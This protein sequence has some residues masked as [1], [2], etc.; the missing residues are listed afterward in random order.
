M[1]EPLHF[2]DRLWSHRAGIV[3]SPLAERSFVHLFTRDGLTFDNN[4]SSRGNW[5]TGIFANDYGHRRPLQPA[6]PI[7]FRDSTRHFDTARQVQKGILTKR[8]R[9]FARLP[10][11][12]IF[13]APDAAL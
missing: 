2:H 8:N 9:D 1:I 11:R 12:K 5:Q 6:H 7:V 10:A 13:F 4:L 3:S